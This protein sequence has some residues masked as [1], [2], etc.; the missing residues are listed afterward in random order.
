MTGRP[1]NSQS[2]NK[3]RAEGKPENKGQKVQKPAPQASVSKN[4]ASVSV[5]TPAR[6][7]VFPQKAS[8]VFPVPNQPSVPIL[9]SFRETMLSEKSS[10]ASGE[11][12]LARE[13]FK[14]TAANLGLPRDALSVA[15]LVFARFF[16]LPL[17]LELIGQL[18]REILASGKSSSPQTAREE[19]EMEAEAL[20]AVIAADKGVTLS[21][22]ALAHYASFFVSPALW[23]DEKNLNNRKN[24]PEPEG[25]QSI[26][27]ENGREDDLLSL[28]NAIPGKNGQHWMVFP[29]SL[30]DD[31][32]ELNVFLRVLK[33]DLVST[34]ESEQL[35]ADISGPKRQWHCFL[36]KKDGKLQADIQVFPKCSPRGLNLLQKDAEHFLRKESGILGPIEGFGEILVRNG[37]GAPSWVE[38]LSTVC[39]SSIIDKDV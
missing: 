5:K 16:S 28:L 38:D 13:L 18:R 22:E 21:P 39:L 11:Q 14:Q 4:P 17:G 35:I 7:A 19:A 32:T 12:I 34:V 24:N 31:D 23:K 9:N 6:G 25:L 8:S 30:K 1:K 20:A 26:A 10:A 33:S 36:K 29:F 3:S 37:D 15:L 27:E 2:L